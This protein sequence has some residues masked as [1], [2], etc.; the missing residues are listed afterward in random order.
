MA[1]TEWGSAVGRLQQQMA[2]DEWH[3]GGTAK[4]EKTEGD[5]ERRG[6]EKGGG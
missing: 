2:E 1:M 3:G 6:G 4:E 5:R